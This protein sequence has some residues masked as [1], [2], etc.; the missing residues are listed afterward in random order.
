MPLF[1][2]YH[3][4][5]SSVIY[6]WTEARQH[7][8]YLLNLIFQT[9]F[10]TLL[11]EAEWCCLSTFFIVII[12]WLNNH[13]NSF[14]CPV[15]HGTTKLYSLATILVLRTA[16]CILTA[17]KTRAT[18]NLVNMTSFAPSQWLEH[19]TG[20]RKAWVRFPSVFLFPTLV[21]NWMYSILC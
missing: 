17:C 4:L 15:Q 2:S 3:I 9:Y 19:P 12:F 18:M 14:G 6:Y 1:C 11:D 7:G 13:V 8:I 5:T 16:Y 10:A 21:T 20:V